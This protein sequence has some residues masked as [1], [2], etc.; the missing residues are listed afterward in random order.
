[1]INIDKVIG[2]CIVPTDQP[3]ESI[4]VRGGK[5]ELDKKFVEIK[6]VW[7]W[8]DE[9]LSNCEIYPVYSDPITVTYKPATVNINF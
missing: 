7:C 5:E 2:W 6:D 3:D 9:E 8:D 4:F 1:M